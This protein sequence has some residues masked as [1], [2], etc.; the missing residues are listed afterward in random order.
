MIHDKRYVL[1]VFQILSNDVVQK[2][3]T[4]MYGCG[5]QYNSGQFAFDV[6]FKIIYFDFTLIL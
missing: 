3:V 2:V 4:L 5:M 6:R 1:Y